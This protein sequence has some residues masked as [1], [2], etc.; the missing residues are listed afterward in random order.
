[1]TASISS[2]DRFAISPNFKGRRQNL[3]RARRHF[4]RGG[5]TAT[6]LK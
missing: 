2:I 3:S 6:V 5:K 4:R 1:M